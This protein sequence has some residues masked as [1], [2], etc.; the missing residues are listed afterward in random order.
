M[1]NVRR[2]PF[3]I[4]SLGQACMLL[5]VSFLYLFQVKEYS[6]LS[7]LRAVDGLYML[8]GIEIVLVEGFLIYYISEQKL[9]VLRILFIKKGQN[10][11]IHDPFQ[12]S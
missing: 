6:S 4:V 7:G 1:K 5:F 3:I 2:I 10:L 8:V 9:T 11:V 12:M